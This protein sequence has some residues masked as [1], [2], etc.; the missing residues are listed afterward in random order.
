MNL[1]LTTTEQAFRAEVRAFIADNL[2]AE[3]RQ[4]Q[5]L[6]TGVFP[7]PEVSLPWHRRLAARG[8][9]APLWPRAHGGTGWTAIQR[10][11]FECECA[12]AG[13][14]LIYPL[15]VRLAGPVIIAFG[16]DAQKQRYLPR[17]LSGEDYWC[18][19]FSEPGAGS[20]LASLTTRAVA[21]GE[22]YIV[23]GSKIWTT[24][25]HHANRM[26]TLVRT[27]TDGRKQDGIS[28]L[29]IDM[30]SPGVE[31]RPIISIGGEHDLNQVFLTDVRVPRANRIGE[32]NKGWT[33]A[34]YLLEFE[35]G[36]GLFSSRLRAGLGRIERAMDAM[37]AEG[38][39]PRRDRGLMAR[40]AEVAI[41]IDCFEMLELKTLGGLRP[42]ESPGSVASVLKLRASRLKQAVGEIGVEILSA[43]A[44]RWTPRPTVPGEAIPGD[45]L[46]SRAATIFG[47]AAEVQL[48]L[49]ARA[50]TGP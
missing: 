36:A 12:A 29:V 31:V 13:A 14:P 45:Y 43:R 33:Y 44:L 2:T 48:G 37:A 8:W 1:D 38:D 15:G 30:D 16:S 24:H 32:E 3:M 40:L 18:Q 7:E 20:D 9:V 46:N 27:G 49:I 10:F 34:K 41:D 42:G 26:F 39:D 47:G 4:G 28:F 50:L 22:D 5:R 23:N 11:I 21:D 25:A 19:G 35:R 17:I 6:T